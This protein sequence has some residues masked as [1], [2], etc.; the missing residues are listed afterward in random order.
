MEGGKE[1]SY[2]SNGVAIDVWL[3]LRHHVE[4]KYVL[5]LYIKWSDSLDEKEYEKEYFGEMK[6]EIALFRLKIRDKDCQAIEAETREGDWTE[7]DKESRSMN[8]DTEILRGMMWEVAS[9]QYDS[10]STWRER[11]YR[12]AIFHRSGKSTRKNSCTDV[13]QWT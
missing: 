1:Y 3:K 7:K 11:E 13:Q 6:R 4:Q 12:Y 2:W 10:L 9:N 8:M 5:V